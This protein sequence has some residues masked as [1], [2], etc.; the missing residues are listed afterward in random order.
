M[1]IISVTIDLAMSA[2]FEVVGQ[3]A[4]FD[5]DSRLSPYCHSEIETV[6]GLKFVNV[7]HAYRILCAAYLKFS[8][9]HM[10]RLYN[11][12]EHTFSLRWHALHDNDMN[13]SYSRLE[14]FFEYERHFQL[15]NAIDA[16]VY[17]RIY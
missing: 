13:F 3:F 14:H 12:P 17:C 4:L 1:R 9:V 15:R 8:T 16:K 5:D 11:C 2:E 10:E 6:D 7:M